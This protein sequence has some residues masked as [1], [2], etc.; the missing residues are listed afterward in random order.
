[1][2]GRVTAHG[3]CDSFSKWCS[4]PVPK[5]FKVMR[6]LIASA[7]IRTSQSVAEVVA[8]GLCIG[9]GLCE[10]LTAGRSRM[11]MTSGGSLRPVPHDRFTEAEEG[12]I[13]ASCP[14]TVS[15]GQWSALRPRVGR[16]LQDAVCLGQKSG[17]PLSRLF[18][19]DVDR[20]RMPSAQ[21]ASCGIC[22]PRRCRPS[23]S[24]AIDVVSQ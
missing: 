22:S 17:Y 3:S 23:L 21:G 12:L 8:N 20:T 11:T 19:R 24:D 5:K 6:L 7:D 10:A 16:L 2:N 14:G 4:M 9:C 13:L 15:R 18:W 1:M